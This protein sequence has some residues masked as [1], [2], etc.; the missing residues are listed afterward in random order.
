MKCVRLFLAAVTML[1]GAAFCAPA[2]AGPTDDAL[3]RG[4]KLFADPGLGTSG[5][6]CSSCHGQGAAWAGKQRFPKVALGGVHTLDQAIQ[7][8]IAT[9]LQGRPLA[10]DDD[11]LTALAVYVDSLYSPAGK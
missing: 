10:W 6:A 9:P 7:I 1:A 3:A 2:L 5:K 4:A 8:C 11:R